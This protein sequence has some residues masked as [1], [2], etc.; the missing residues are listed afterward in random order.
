[1]PVYQDNSALLQL[2]TS[3]QQQHH[4]PEQ[5]LVCDGAAD[6]QCQ[7]ICQ[8][9]SAGWLASKPGRGA[10]LDLAA[11]QATGDILWF[12]HADSQLA[13]NAIELIHIA[14]ANGQNGGWFQFSFIGQHGWLATLIE[15]MTNW[16]CKKGIPYG[17]QGLFCL[18]SDYLKADGFEHL[19][20]FE[21]V[22]LVKRLRQ[23]GQFL[24]LQQTIGVDARR[25]QHDGWVKRIILN[26]AFALLYMLGV[27]PHRLASWYRSWK[28][29]S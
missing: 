27:S 25:W 16:R 6:P 26:R 7:Q 12:V 28:T 2:L 23:L 11:R 8:Q 18:K 24:P 3:L 22:R 19:P 21:E 20:L 9:F 15:K 5:I 13:E 4:R 10:Q 29:H 1:M 14:I 17:D